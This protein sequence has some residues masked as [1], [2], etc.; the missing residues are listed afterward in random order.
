MSM[1]ERLTIGAATRPKLA[2]HARLRFDTARGLWLLLA[3][4][5]V[6]L[7]DPIAV[8][9]LELSDGIRTVRDVAENLS[10]KYD[11]PLDRIATDVTAMLQSLADKGFVAAADGVRP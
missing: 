10:Q 6:L 3:P 1:A 7:P 4:E 11:A 2:R 9:V 8:E 5:R